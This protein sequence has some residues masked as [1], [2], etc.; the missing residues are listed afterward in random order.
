MGHGQE[1]RGEVPL[2]VVGQASRVGQDDERRQVVR[3]RAQAIRDPGPQA[4]EARE[5][6]PGVHHVAGRAVDVRLRGQR[7]QERH[8]VDAGRQVRED[9]R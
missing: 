5:Q 3:Q 2:R 9:A 8:V 7:H 1:A 6:E 4:R